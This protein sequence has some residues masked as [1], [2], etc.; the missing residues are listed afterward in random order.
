MLDLTN[1]C[2]SGT[3]VLLYGIQLSASNSSPDPKA[4]SYS[5]ALAGS[6]KDITAAEFAKQL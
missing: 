6:P 3:P 4:H 5:S 2:G 1:Q